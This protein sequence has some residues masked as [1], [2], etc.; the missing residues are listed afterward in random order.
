[1]T[2]DHTMSISCHV[3]ARASLV[4]ESIE[5]ALQSARDTLFRAEYRKLTLNDIE[6]PDCIK[7]PFEIIRK[8]HGDERARDLE[9]QDDLKCILSELESCLLHEL[10]AQEKT[11]WDIQGYE[12]GEESDNGEAVE[13]S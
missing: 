5:A 2:R 1:M 13:G 6:F 11:L 9:Y 4:I 8:T 12:T 3:L 10:R 7:D